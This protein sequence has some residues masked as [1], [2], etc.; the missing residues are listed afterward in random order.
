MAYDPTKYKQESI[1]SW[2]SRARD[3]HD[4][5]AGAGRGPFRSTK[6]L[7]DAAG[8]LE[9]DFVL[10]VACGTGAVSKEAFLRLGPSGML[11]GIDFARGALRIAKENVPAGH[12][13]EMDAENIGLRARFDKVLCQYA[14]MF[15]PEPVRV[16]GELRRLLKKGGRI[17]VA[18]HGTAQG[19]PYFSTIMEP[20]LK[21]I[22]DIRPEGAPTVHRFGNPKDLENA[23]ASAG[24]ANVAVRKFVFDYEAGP[25]SEYWSDYMATTAAAIRSKIEARGSQVVADIKKEAEEKAQRFVKDGKIRFP[26]DVLVA[27]AT[28]STTT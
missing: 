7:V 21:R 2:N 22:P 4:G 5:W 3:Y 6:E 16:L 24:F 27:T 18:V 23:L 26:W 9:S 28:S 11:A 19:V 8:I 14:L 15:F 17:A 1:V 12:F 20:V 25:F 10:D 13:V